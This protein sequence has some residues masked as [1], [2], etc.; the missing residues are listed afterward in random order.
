MSLYGIEKK[1]RDIVL[2]ALVLLC[3]TVFF[4][5]ITNTK[6]TRNRVGTVPITRTTIAPSSPFNA[7]SFW[8]TEKT[9]V[10]STAL[11]IGIVSQNTT[12]YQ[13]VTFNRTD[14][15]FDAPNWVDAS[16]LTLRVYATLFTPTNASGTLPLT[17]GVIVVHGTGQRRQDFF[18]AGLSFAEMNC[19]AL[20]ID[21]VGHGESQ[22]PGPTAEYTIYQGDFNKTSYHY[23]AFCNGLQ[24]V[25]VM[26][27]LTSLVDPARIAITGFSLGGITAEIVGAIYHDK[28]ALVMPAGAINLTCAFPETAI[29]NLAGLTYEEL[30]ALSETTFQYVNPLNYMVM[31]QY[32][33]TCSF[34]GTTDEYFSYK[35]IPDVWQALQASSNM[36]WLQVTPN[37]HH[38]YPTDQTTHYLLR[39]E[40]FSGPSP[41]AITITR[42][43]KT[44]GAME[45][46][47]V[48]ATVMSPTSIRSVEICYRY[49]D[50]IGEAWRT[51]AMRSSG[52]N[53]WTGAVESPW[54]TS[55]M[56]CFVKVTLET[57]EDVFFTSS[58]LEAGVLTNYLSFLPVAGIVAAVA[59]PI[60]FSLKDRYKVEVAGLDEKR[61]GAA[62]KH[63]IAENVFLAGTET[64]KFSSMALPWM[65]Y[66]T[67]P[68]SL[69]YIMQAYFTY[70]GALGDL[71]FFFNGILFVAFFAIAVTSTMNPLLSGILNTIWAAFFYFLCDL[72]YRS[73]GGTMSADILGT[74]FYL[75]LSSALAQVGIWVWKRIYHKRLGIPTRN[76]VTIIKGAQKSRSMKI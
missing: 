71:A 47:E 39:H 17:P 40:F 2:Y 49:T 31:A 50:I 67:V 11:N 27:S 26:Q 62:K 69:F 76:L 9:R 21:L 19:S 36:K 42:S 4:I 56:D 55:Q 63:F 51:T 20:V 3:I 60:L 33:D 58:L 28:I 16:P 46:F 54:V 38:S 72:M 12:T 73:F 29:R 48:D 5:G 61:R 23:L 59:I 70:D 6:S 65:M 24:A 14:L 41:P 35:G 7:T 43:V 75:Y 25:R 22:G 1:K 64:V 52:A 15:A 30:L 57:G 37:G 10:E 45:R 13:G 34:M 8:D 53:L 74:G 32:P 44:S 66:G 18:T 68:W